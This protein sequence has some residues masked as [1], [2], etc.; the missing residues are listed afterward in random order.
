MAHQVTLTIPDGDYN[1][2][3]ALIK[4]F[5]WKVEEEE[6]TFNLTQE[7]KDRLDNRLKHFKENPSD[8]TE[9]D[10]FMKELDNEV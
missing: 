3:Q 2:F 7:Q 6:Q 4:K 9:W 8:I 1:F 5:R 10:S